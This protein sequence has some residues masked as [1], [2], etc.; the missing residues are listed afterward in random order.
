MRGILNVTANYFLSLTADGL[1][2]S[3]ALADAQNQGYAEADPAD[4]LEG[5]DV[6]ANALTVY[7]GINFVIVLYRFLLRTYFSGSHRES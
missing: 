4:D 7:M 5:H 2:Y 3:N 1:D 6:V